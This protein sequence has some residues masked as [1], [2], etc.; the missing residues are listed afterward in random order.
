M[1]RGTNFPWN[2]PSRH[3][4]LT[5]LYR[6]YRSEPQVSSIEALPALAM[7]SSLF[8]FGP[9]RAKLA[10]ERESNLKELCSMEWTTPRHEEVDLNC[11]V[12]S[13]ANAEL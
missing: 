7:A 1:G 13:Y 12:S 8:P 11:E 5:L 2:T 3:F 9:T 6:R 4:L 10:H